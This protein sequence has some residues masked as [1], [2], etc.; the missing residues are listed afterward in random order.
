MNRGT[1]LVPEKPSGKANRAE[2][3]VEWRAV[4]RR[5]GVRIFLGRPTANAIPTSSGLN[6]DAGRSANRPKQ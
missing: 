1:Y 3:S 6:S 4:V 5:I 2:Y